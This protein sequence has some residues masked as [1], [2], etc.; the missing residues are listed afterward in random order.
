MNWE[1]NKVTRL[2]QG[3]IGIQ[4]YF[5]RSKIQEKKTNERRKNNNKTHRDR[6]KHKIV[7][8]RVN[9]MREIETVMEKKHICIWNL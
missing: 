1:L 4:L 9:R 5:D 8:A 3:T 6:H 2:S 7:Y